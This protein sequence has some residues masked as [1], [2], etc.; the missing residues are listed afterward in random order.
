MQHRWIA[1]TLGHGNAMCAHCFITDLEANAIKK[2]E[3]TAGL[4]EPEPAHKL[5]DGHTAT[6]LTFKKRDD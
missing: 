4:P 2:Y 1:S 3:C 6:I 5:P